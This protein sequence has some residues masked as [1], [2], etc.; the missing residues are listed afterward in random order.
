M[1]KY[2]DG[3]KRLWPTEFG[4]GLHGSPVAGY[5]YAT[6]NSEQAQGDCI[7]ACSFEMMRNWGWVGVPFLWNL[8]TMFHIRVR[9]WQ[10][11][12]SW[13]GPRRHPAGMAK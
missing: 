8:T 12:A 13:A 11:S 1:V 2:G 4:S 9:N 5:E 3:N 6:Y 10:P 7:P